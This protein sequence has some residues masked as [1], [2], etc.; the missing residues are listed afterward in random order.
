VHLMPLS[1]FIFSLFAG[2]GDADANASDNTNESI[3]QKE[4]VVIDELFV[5]RNRS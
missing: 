4:E 3:I 1:L 2:N 5:S